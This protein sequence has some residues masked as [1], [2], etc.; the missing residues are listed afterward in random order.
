[1]VKLK[2]GIYSDIR[3]TRIEK[4]ENE[5]D[6]E[7]L[8]QEEDVVITLSHAGYIKRISADVYSAQKR[9]GKG[10]QA[11]TTK[12][13]DFV[14]NI[15]ITSTHANLL[16]FTNKGKAYKLKAYEIPDAGRTA[17]G[18]NLINLL[19]LETDEVIQAVLA[20]KELDQDG[21]LFMCT[22]QGIVKKT[23]L[24]EFKNLRRN[25][26][27]AL[28]LKDG[29]E[30]LKV[31]VT[32]GDADIMIITEKGYS[33]RFNEKDVRPM[34]RTAA[35]VKAIT[36]RDNDIAVCMD[37]AVED[38]K[39]LVISENGYGK[40]TNIDEYKL[41]NRGGMGLITYKLSDKTGKVVGAT[42]CKDDDELMLI[43]SNG[44]AIRINVADISI[45][46]RSAMGVKLMRTLED[47]S[48]VAI[49]KIPGTDKEVEDEIILSDNEVASE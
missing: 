24:S 8:I 4:Q 26:L 21:Y 35:G 3:R 13:D 18:M 12:E 47:E 27:I 16:F 31:K 48:V 6:I 30:L 1:M 2:S 10:I 29:D 32:Y 19:P 17:K 45:T 28:S 46:S 11:M 44:V 49:A 14:E 43:N 7:D 39:V 15:F 40:R 22:K 41:Q 5:I 38:E 33:I 25:G 23:R 36:L 42:I 9:G 34:G 37:I 20:L